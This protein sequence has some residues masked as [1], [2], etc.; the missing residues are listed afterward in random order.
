MNQ[1]RDDCVTSRM[2][3][4]PPVTVL[5]TRKPLP[6]R[7]VEFE[8]YVLGITQAAMRQP[9]HLGTNVFRPSKPDG[10]YRI[11]FK[12]DR[13]SNLV[14]W[15]NS[16]ERADWRAIAQ[17]VSQ[18]REVQTISGLEAWFTLPDCAINVHPPK[19]KMAFLVWL[20]VFSLVTLLSYLVG[21]LMEGWPLVVRSFTLTVIVVSTLTY[22][23]LPGLTRLFARWLYPKD[24][25]E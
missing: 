3:G 5:V 21:P 13:R 20:G 16:D 23:V 24:Q 22:L 6:G 19:Y 2:E 11:V 9:G 12:F 10:A 25:S 17:S 15:E 1:V 18:P 8:D 14:R 7:E 4:D